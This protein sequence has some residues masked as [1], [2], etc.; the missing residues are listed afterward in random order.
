MV[1]AAA[2][3]RHAAPGLYYAPQLW[4]T[5]DGVIPYRRFW[6]EYLLM[7]SHRTSTQLA[8]RGAIA[9]AM[10]GEEVQSTLHEMHAH[11]SPTF[12]GA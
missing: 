9:L 11:A 12:I 7:T 6:A 2:Q 8:I 10:G 4:G 3:L 5:T 1:W